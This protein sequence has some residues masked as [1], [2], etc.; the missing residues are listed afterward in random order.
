MS[1]SLLACGQIIPSGIE[2]AIFIAVVIGATV[3]PFVIG[4]LVLAL[5]FKGIQSLAHRV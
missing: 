3:A 4:G 5:V 2:G 1:A